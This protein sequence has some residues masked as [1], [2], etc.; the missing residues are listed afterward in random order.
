M[1][2][3]E[4]G[5]VA[6]T[7]QYLDMSRAEYASLEHVVRDVARAV[8]MHNDNP[9]FWSDVL[10]SPA[11]AADWTA[12]SPSNYALTFFSLRLLELAIDPMPAVDFSGGAWLLLNSFES[13]AWMAEKYV[14]ADT[15][16]PSFEQ[17]RDLVTAA[18]QEA[19]ERERQPPPSPSEA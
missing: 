4:P 14:R 6:N 5:T 13:S 8:D 17:R 18:L 19:I 3:A 7:Q 10:D 12:G 2:V 11:V 16:G 1:R 9:F 15:E